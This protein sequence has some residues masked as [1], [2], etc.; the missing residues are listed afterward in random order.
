[1][2]GAEADLVWPLGLNGYEPRILYNTAGQWVDVDGPKWHQ[3]ID[4]GARPLEYVFAVEDGTVVA[5]DLVEDSTDQFQCV[6]VSRGED[7]TNGIKYMHLASSLVDVGDPVVRDQ[8]LGTVVEWSASCGFDHLHLQVVTNNSPE[9]ANESVWQLAHALD[10]GNPLLLFAARPDS[11]PPVLAPQATKDGLEAMLLLFE[12]GTTDEVAP[13]AVSGPIDVVARVH[14]LFPGTGPVFDKDTSPCAEQPPAV[15]LAPLRLELR[16]V[17]PEPEP[18][19]PVLERRPFGETV[20]T[21]VIDLSGAVPPLVED[22][23]SIYREESKGTYT[24]HDLLFVLTH[25]KETAL[26]AWDPEDSGVYRLDLVVQDASYNVTSYS[27]HVTVEL[28]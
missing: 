9:A 13:D 20:Y 26:G 12:D 14:D 27:M 21:N 17:V 19:E 15:E 4:L 16:V 3:G 1:V 5:T 8:V 11:K 28:P 24:E 7:L 22:P 6:V 2:S 25:D 10:S 18:D 23:T